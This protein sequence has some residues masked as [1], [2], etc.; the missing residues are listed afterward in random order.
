MLRLAVEQRFELAT[1]LHSCKN[2]SNASWEMQQ[3]LG[4][5]EKPAKQA[6]IM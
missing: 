5:K 4:L 2:R 3:C 1:T 6:F